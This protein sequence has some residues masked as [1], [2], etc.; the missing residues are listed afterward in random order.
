MGLRINVDLETSGGP[1]Q[2]LYVRIDTLNLNKVA[3]KIKYFVS[4]WIDKDHALR[5]NRTYL[6]QARPGANG[7]VAREVVYYADE[8]SDGT[9]LTLPLLFETRPVSKQIITLPVYEMKPT[10]VEVPYVSFDENGDEVTKYRKIEE[11]KRVEVG[12]KEEERH[13]I[14]NEKLF[15]IQETCYEDMKK[16]L[17]EIFPLDSIENA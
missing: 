12:K 7:I 15:N 16:Q 10:V 17:S 8:N 9:E 14:D 2:E 11:E 1:T 6:E 3:S 5:F 13:I 4:Y